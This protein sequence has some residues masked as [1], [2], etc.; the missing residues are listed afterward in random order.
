MART[1]DVLQI[2]LE[3]QGDGTVKASLAEIGKA[4][5]KAGKGASAAAGGVK[6]L[7]DA[8]AAF[9]VAKMVQGLIQINL[10]AEQLRVQLRTLE[11]SQAAATERFAQLQEMAR[12]TPLS[13]N[14]VT[15]AYVKLKNFGLDPLDGTM[16]SIIDTGAALGG[17][18]ETING[19]IMAFGQANAKGKLQGEEMLQMAER[20]VPVYDTLARALGKTT[21]EIQEMASKG[22]LGRDS[23]K[24]LADELGKANFGAA[25]AQANTMDGAIGALKDNIEQLAIAIGDSGLAAAFT[26]LLRDVAAGIAVLTDWINETGDANTEAS[27][28]ASVLKVL[29][30]AMDVIAVGAKLGGV[31]IGV[32]VDIF[33]ALASVAVAAGKAV[34]GQF[35]AMA[36]AATG[37]FKGAMAV[38]G[39]TIGG[40]PEAIK[41]A[42]DRMAVAL[43][44]GVE[45]SARHVQELRNA[46]AAL[47][48]ASADAAPRVAKSATTAGAAVSEGAKKARAEIERMIVALAREVS[49]H[50]KSET[51]LLR[52]AASRLKAAGASAEHVAVLNRLID[53]KERLA[54]EEEAQARRDK[55]AERLQRAA[56]DAAKELVALRREQAATLGGPAVEASQRYADVLD[57]IAAAEKTLL[58]LGPPTLAQIEAIAKARSDAAKI[59][60]KERKDAERA[61]RDMA[62][63]QVEGYE[64]VWLRGIQDLGPA[65]TDGLMSGDWSDVGKRL[66]ESIL[67]GLLDAFMDEAVVKPMQDA[68]MA[69]IGGGEGG[70]DFSSF[71]ESLQG[72]GSGS[73]G[74][75]VGSS[76]TGA[77]GWDMTR[78]GGLIGGGMMAYGG[79]QSGSWLQGAAGGAMAGASFGP[80]GMAIGAIIG[81][82]AGALGGDKDP[83]LTVGGVGRTRDP[84][85]TFTTAFGAQQIGVRGGMPMEDFIT[86]IQQFDQQIAS[87]IRSVGG[88]SEGIAA[89]T[90]AL[91]G[92]SADLKGG[93]ATMEN[94]LNQRLEAIIRAAEPAWAGFLNQIAGVSERVEAFTALYAIRDQIDALDEAAATLA[95]GPLEQ[96][97]AQLAGLSRTV[98]DSMSAL[99]TA[100]EGRNPVEIQAAAAAAQQAVIDRYNAEIQLVRDLENALLSAQQQARQMDLALSQRIAGVTGD[101]ADVADTA[102]VGMITTRAGVEGSIDPERA[103]AFLDE[104]IGNVDAWLQASIAQVNKLAQAEQERINTALAGIAAQQQALQQALAALDAERNGIIAGANQ[105]AQEAAAQANAMAQAIAESR[106]AAAQAQIDALQEQISLAREFQRVL[107]EARAMIEQLTFSAANPLGGQARLELLNQEIAAAEAAMN[108][109]SGA[110]QVAAADRLLSLLNQRLQLVQGEGLMQRPGD[111]Y[112]A[113]YNQTLQ[114]I[115]GVQAIA[116]PEADLGII[117]QQELNRLQQQSN[118]TVGS[119][120][121]TVTYTADEQ[122]RLAQIAEEEAR[123]QAE[124]RA[125]DEESAELQKELLR[126][127][128]DAEAQIRQLNEDARKQYEW[129]RGEGARLQAERAE[130]LQQQI[131]LIT[132]GRPIDEF[133][134]DRQAESTRLLGLISTDLRAFLDAISS[135]STPTLPGGPGGPGGPRNPTPEPNPPGA[136]QPGI[137]RVG[138]GVNLAP[139]IVINVGSGDPQQIAAAVGVV[140]QRDLPQIAT[141]IKRELSVA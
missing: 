31:Q 12:S 15:E 118:Q 30:Q 2:K 76:A 53:A 95:G 96:L 35:H 42:T 7:G 125:L 27:A 44:T 23:I 67:T 89:I 69:A 52:E 98:D 59:S 36:L 80:W 65:L 97:K 77:G 6:M 110:D 91:A 14:Q 64:A 120:A 129:A 132:D 55:E 85:T 54:Q 103:L 11:G 73:A 84:R 56:T 121:A 38:L 126:V 5:E 4:G 102:R 79:Y 90:S 50:G 111:D 71:F 134:A 116:A 139:E 137:N 141:R 18:F 33:A 93:A 100:I 60:A 127:Q 22:Q 57:V 113:L 124:M 135:G 9:G 25:A 43:R 112:L 87:L 45:E 1:T 68:F 104:F 138:Y 34:V 32:M 49:E 78:I 101:Y 28:L 24:L 51:Q 115:A 94:L 47:D 40:V 75:G 70:F 8:V 46:W 99:D 105:R 83:Y 107:D 114:Q 81:G 39:T 122:A 128:Q 117:L 74:S 133:I 48:K 19:L 13:V 136:P 26:G 82:L 130:R 86:K 66:G 10:E 123:I 72:G 88:G 20:G 3:I 41:D 119:I 106:Q 108:S 16:Q 21:G 62:M 17:G 37:D 140:L 92:W 63:R 58:D 61:A 109:A 131:D 29:G